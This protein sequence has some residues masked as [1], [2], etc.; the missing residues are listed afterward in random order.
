[1]DITDTEKTTD[2]TG[3][4]DSDTATDEPVPEKPLYGD[5]DC[6]GKVTMED[7]VAL[8]KIMAKLAT[9]ED[10]GKMSRINSDCVHDDVI[11]MMDVTEIQKFLAKLIP[12]LDP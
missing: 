4:K 9:H 11:N 6:N 2:T 8:Q 1:M 3:P 12:D 5:V 7:V 10:Y